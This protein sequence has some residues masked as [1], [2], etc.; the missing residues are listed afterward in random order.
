MDTKQE[1]L[2]IRE[3]IIAVF[4]KWKQ[5][6]IITLIVG[7]LGFSGNFND[8]SKVYSNVQCFH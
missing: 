8:A 5:I 2:D 3:L 1:E 6:L 4:R 7:G